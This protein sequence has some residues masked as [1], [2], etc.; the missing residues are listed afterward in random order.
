MP[1]VGDCLAVYNSVVGAGVADVDAEN[2]D[3]RLEG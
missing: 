1:G 2:H 3:K